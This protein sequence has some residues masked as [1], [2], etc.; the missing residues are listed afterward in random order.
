MRSSFISHLT[1]KLFHAE[2]A[3]MKTAFTNLI[4]VLLLWFG[5]GVGPSLN[6]PPKCGCEDKANGFEVNCENKGFTSPINPND[7]P[8]NT[9]KL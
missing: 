9:Y 8:A 7:L 4:F 6:C 5:C 2:R 1:T 3:I